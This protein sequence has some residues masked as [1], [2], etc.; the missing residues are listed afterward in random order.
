MSVRKT[1]LS[2]TERQSPLLNSLNIFSSKSVAAYQVEL[3]SAPKL[4][5]LYQR[6]PIQA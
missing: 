3:L 4:K 6:L 5:S 1:H 2:I